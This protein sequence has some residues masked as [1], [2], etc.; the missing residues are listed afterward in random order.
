M[1]VS[2]AADKLE[3]KIEHRR[4]LIAAETRIIEGHLEAIRLM[5]AEL[6]ALDKEKRD[7]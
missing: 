4:Q 2:S 1:T 5:T 3:A 7:W 6:I